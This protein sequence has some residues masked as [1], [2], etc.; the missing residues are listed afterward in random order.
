MITAGGL[1]LCVIAYM[2]IGMIWYSPILFGNVW[3]KLT[4]RG[5]HTAKKE[6]MNVLYMVSASSSFIMAAVLNYVMA[7]VEIQTVQE[8]LLLGFM[9]WLGFTYPSTMVNALFQGKPRK[10]I[11]IDSGYYLVSILI[12]SIILFFLMYP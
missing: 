5:S 11:F 7:E 2:I 12:M 3:S 6:E 9:L 10:L 8:A 1:A 4:G